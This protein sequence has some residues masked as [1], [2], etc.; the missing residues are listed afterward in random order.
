MSESLIF[1]LAKCIAALLVFVGIFCVSIGLAQARSLPGR[2]YMDSY[3]AY[4]E[5]VIR[6]CFLKARP[7][8]ILRAQLVLFACG[9]VVVAVSHSATALLLPAI[10]A[11]GPAAYLR[12]IRRRRSKKVTAQTDSFLLGLAN[13]L[14]A[15]PTIGAALTGLLPVLQSPLREEITLALNE[16][17]VGNSIDQALL[18][19]ASRAQSPALDGALSA[20]L[21]GRQVGGELPKILETTAATL[22]EIHRL[23][24]VVQSKTSESRAQL[25]V[26]A[27]FPLGILFLFSSVSPGFFDPLFHTFVGQI[28]SVVAMVFWG[29]AILLARQ[30]SRVDL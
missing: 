15:V 26:L 4:L 9:L 2:R 21:V 29:A 11:F 13:S 14:K 10:A 27:C 1:L 17:R 24:G 23:E 16:L 12:L 20:L 19:V 22:R 30:L 18:N 3:L 5:R 28:V 8:A 6:L 7:I 25:W